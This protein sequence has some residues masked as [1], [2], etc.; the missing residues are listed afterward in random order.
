MAERLHLAGRNL[1]AVNHGAPRSKI[2]FSITSERQPISQ[3]GLKPKGGVTKARPSSQSVAKT[4]SRKLTNG[5]QLSTLRASGIQ[6]KETISEDCS[7]DSRLHRKRL[8]AVAGF[9]GKATLKTENAV[10]EIPV[11]HYTTGPSDQS[12]NFFK[13]SDEGKY[14]GQFRPPFAAPIAHQQGQIVVPISG[15]PRHLTSFNRSSATSIPRYDLPRVNS[16]PQ[17]VVSSRG[18]I[19]SR[20]QSQLESSSSD[21]GYYPP[22]CIPPTPQRFHILSLCLITNNTVDLVGSDA[23]QLGHQMLVAHATYSVRPPIRPTR[24]S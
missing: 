16:M 7:D 10:Q 8:L 18:R 13:G 2:G 12:R 23:Q 15:A 20:T 17:P 19:R 6:N 11:Q 3:A 22:P 9:R 24:G 1:P 21:E 14:P 5:S 4:I